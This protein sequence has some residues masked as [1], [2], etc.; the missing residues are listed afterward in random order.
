M[1]VAQ[2]GEANSISNV[3]ELTAGRGRTNHLSQKPL[4]TRGSQHID[5]SNKYQADAKSS[6]YPHPSMRPAAWA[7]KWIS[8]EH[9]C[10]YCFQWGHWA[11]DFPRK[12]AGSPPLRIPISDTTSQNLYCIRHLSVLR[13]KTKAKPT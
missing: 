7:T 5:S 12:S 10:S 8:P 2:R 11:M 9:P 4:L 6:G 3:M 13:R 1:Q